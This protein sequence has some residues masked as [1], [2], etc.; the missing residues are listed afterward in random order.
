MTQ[1]QESEAA[2]DCLE[3]LLDAG[4]RWNPEFKSLDSVR[5]DLLRNSPRFIV[6]VIRLLLYVPGAADHA[7]IAELCRTPVIARK[8]YEGDRALAEELDALRADLKR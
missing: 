8:I 2:A 7:T 1:T 4:A 6:R 5:R 3:V